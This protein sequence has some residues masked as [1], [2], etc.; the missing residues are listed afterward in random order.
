MVDITTQLDAVTR[1]LRTERIDGH[2]CRVQALAQEYPS[3]IADVWQAVTSADRIAR[4][5]LPVSGDLR[6]GGRYDLQGNASGEILECDPPDDG[7]AAYRLTWESMG[8]ISWV[9]VALTAVTPDRTRFELEHTARVAD[10]PD[11]MWDAFGPAG[12]GVG[13]D[14]GLLGLGLH[15]GSIDGE[16][17]PEQAEAWALSEEVRPF[18][19][20]AAERWGQAWVAAGADPEVAA[21]TAEA[22]YRFYTGQTET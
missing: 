17:T 6:L 8:S 9:R 7:A 22:T 12:T 14:G 2:D 19:R 11:Q 16:L 15:L 20:G 10:I 21:R 4:W 5:F 13:W 18:Y 1:S 3:G